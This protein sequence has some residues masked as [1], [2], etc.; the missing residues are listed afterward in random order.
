MK[1]NFT[2]N[3][4]IDEE[5]EANIQCTGTEHVS[6]CGENQTCTCDKGF[7]RLEEVCVP[8]RFKIDKSMI[9]NTCSIFVNITEVSFLTFGH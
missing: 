8:G 5:C 9:F 4:F 3:K 6:V 7:I 2:G 1:Y